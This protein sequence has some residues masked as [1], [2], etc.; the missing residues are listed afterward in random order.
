[1]LR[2]SV[3]DFIKLETISKNGLYD[4]ETSLQSSLFL[5]SKLINEDIY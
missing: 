5:L 1:M 2:S 3:S 4:T